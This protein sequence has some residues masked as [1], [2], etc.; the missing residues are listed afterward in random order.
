MSRAINLGIYSIRYDQEY[1]LEPA[2][3]DGAGCDKERKRQIEILLSLNYWENSMIL[4]ADNL[5]LLVSIR[6]S[7]LLVLSDLVY[8]LTRSS[9]S[10]SNDI[11]FSPP[12]IESHSGMNTIRPSIPRLSALLRKKQFPM[13]PHGPRLSYSILID[14][15]ISPAYG[16]KYFYAA[17]PGKV[18]ADRYQT[19]VKIGWGVSSTVWLARDLQG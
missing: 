14:E 15:E 4:L 5:L 19:L 9:S 8:K 18:L 6:N 2:A 1:L 13:H 3:I 17:K 12:L 10:T 16:P 11:T 7:H